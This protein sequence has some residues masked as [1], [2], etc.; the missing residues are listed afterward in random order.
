MKSNNDSG[1]VKIKHIEHA[2]FRKQ[3]EM[4]L[5]G[6]LSSRNLLL[7]KKTQMQSRKVGMTEDVII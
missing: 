7:R 3:T 2:L 4:F 6:K 5:N 1:Q